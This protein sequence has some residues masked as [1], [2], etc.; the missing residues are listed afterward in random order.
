M[1]QQSIDQLKLIAAF[2]AELLAAVGQRSQN[3]EQPR[4]TWAELF[5]RDH[6]F[7][8]GAQEEIPVTAEG[9]EGRRSSGHR[10]AR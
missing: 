3:P 4:L 10:L 6:G 7:D 8:L 9:S 5:A 1:S 2:T